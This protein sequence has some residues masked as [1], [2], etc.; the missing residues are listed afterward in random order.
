[1]HTQLTASHC[2]NVSSGLGARY[3]SDLLPPPA[4][5][6]MTSP[7][8][9]N[10]S[11]LPFLF[12]SVFSKPSI[13]T[14]LGGPHPQRCGRANRFLSATSQAVFLGE[15]G[16]M[17]TASRPLSPE[18]SHRGA[19]IVEPAVHSAMCLTDCRLLVPLTA[20][21]AVTGCTLVRDRS[22]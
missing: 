9:H 16:L 13:V 1:M 6:A 4:P 5:V 8:K 15:A 21:D 2:V 7:K 18:T 12:F 14:E 22:P 19:H 20:P 11:N 17:T 10:V 3:E